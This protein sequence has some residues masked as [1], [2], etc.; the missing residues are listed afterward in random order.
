MDE[1]IDAQRMEETHSLLYTASK[2]F[3]AGS[4][5]TVQPIFPELSTSFSPVPRTGLGPCV[6]SVSIC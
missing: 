4:K 6:C 3:S 1:E 2:I 5:A